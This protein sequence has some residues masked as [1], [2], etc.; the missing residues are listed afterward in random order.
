M[1]LNVDLVS[2]MWLP[3]NVECPVCKHQT[4]THFDDYDL[5]CGNPNPERARLELELSCSSCDHSWLHRYRVHAELIDG[6]EDFLSPSEKQTESDD[7]GSEE[8]KE[9]TDSNGNSIRFEIR[10][11]AIAPP[12]RERLGETRK[13][14][15]H[16]FEIM[17]QERPVDGYVTV[18]FYPDGRVG[19][20]FVR[21]SKVGST[22]GSL[23][24]QWAI[25]VSMLLQTGT[26]LGVIC[27]KFAFT[28]F[29]PAGMTKNPD[30]P[31]A[32]SVIDYVARW[33]SDK[34]VRKDESEEEGGTET[35]DGLSKVRSASVR[36]ANVEV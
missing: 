25:A 22:I 33:L 34:F 12:T 1:G 18:G 24:D 21:L 23:A 30:I 31:I 28:R 9:F 8:S 6:Q 35:E 27:E 36:R 11:M 19:E 5:D 20:V 29:E 10:A 17:S 3:K 7:S 14:L 16:H 2:L 32:H 13:S 26:P 15:T 4:P